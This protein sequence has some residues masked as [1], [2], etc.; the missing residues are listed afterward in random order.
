MAK[1]KVFVYGTLKRGHRANA[2]LQDAGFLGETR[3]TLP[4]TMYNLGAFPGVVPGGTGSVFGEVY[5]VTDTILDRLDDYEGVPTLYRRE[6][7]E[8]EQF[9]VCWIYI[10]NHEDSIKKQVVNSGKW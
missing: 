7:V 5:S 6:K 8:T 2:M 4:Y 3:T 1:A 10:Y 9:G